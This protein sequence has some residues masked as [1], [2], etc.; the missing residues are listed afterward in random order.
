[1]ERTDKHLSWVD[2]A[3]VSSVRG[4]IFPLQ[5]FFKGHQTLRII[6]EMQAAEVMSAEDLR[7][8]QEQQLRRFIAHSCDTVKYYSD[9]FRNLRLKSDDIR[10]VSDLV[11]LPLLSKETIRQNL[12]NMKSADAHHVKRFSTGGSTGSPLIFYLG[13]TRIS[14]DVAARWRAESWWGVGIGDPEV[15]LWGSPVELTKQ[16]QLRNLRDQILRTRLYSAFEMSPATM[17]R[18]LDEIER[19]GCRRIFG[20]PSSIVLLCQHAGK[21]GRDLR[22][23]GAH[24]VFVTAEYLWD[25]W[26]QIMHESFGC[27]VANGYGGRDSG[28]IAHECPAGSMHVTAD[29]IIVEIVDD[30]G[31]PLPPAQL[32]EIVV[33]HLD[34]PEMPFIRYRT[35]DM[36]ALGSKPCPCGRGL[37]VLERIEGRKTDFVVAPDGRVLHGLALIYVLREIE[38][39][40]QFR[41]TQK[42]LQTF[43]V[44]IVPGNGYDSR[45]EQKIREGFSHRLRSPV[46][47]HVKYLSRL[48]VSASGKFRYVI[49]EVSD[50]KRGLEN[51]SA[52]ILS[53]RVTGSRQEKA[54][55]ESGSL[56]RGV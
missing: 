40:E 3:Y 12:Q 45:C 34:T 37:P 6:K 42:D 26:R 32:G 27:P 28:F 22:K 10:T 55:V 14:S 56:P 1:V 24:V 21:E 19:G 20:Y 31:R 35:G 50:W 52:E 16:D 25:E 11:C 49:S 41:I 17:S 54:P 30:E 18:Y 13:P 48:T 44:E 15:V 38:G 43:E 5:E 36:G 29:R 46:A 8:L 51:G 9:L 33:T 53:Q 4:V 39:I 23:L 47:V 7:Q 2:K